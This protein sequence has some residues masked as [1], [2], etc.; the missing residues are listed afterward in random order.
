M[1]LMSGKLAVDEIEHGTRPL[2][3]RLPTPGQW[4]VRLS[5]RIITVEH[6]SVLAR[7]WP[8]TAARRMEQTLINI[9]QAPSNEPRQPQ[10]THTM[11]WQSAADGRLSEWHRDRVVTPAVD[12]R[13]S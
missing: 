6:A 9:G 12:G 7:F 1:V 4:E 10:D 11:K 2:G 5:W 13:Q 3:F 8:P